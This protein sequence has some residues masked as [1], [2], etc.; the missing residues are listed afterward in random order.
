MQRETIKEF[1]SEVRLD[2]QQF[3]SCLDSEKYKSHIDK[4]L[5]LVKECDLHT[6]P[7]FLILKSHGTE[8]EVLTG[9][10]LFPSF[11][12]LIDKKIH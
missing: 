9:A 1:A 7:S 3:D 2:R 10:H 12:A 5:A 11:K 4:D 8:M 6:T